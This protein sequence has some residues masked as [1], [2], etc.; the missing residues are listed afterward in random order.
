MMDNTDRVLTADEVSPSTRT[1]ENYQKDV[2]QRQ[3]QIT[4]PIKRQVPKMGRNHLCPCGSQKKIKK[5]GCRVA[6]MFL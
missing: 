3:V 2:R 6:Q 5:C 1:F 4:A